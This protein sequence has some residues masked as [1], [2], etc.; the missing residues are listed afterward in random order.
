MLSAEQLE[1]I[2]NEVSQKL[3]DEGRLI[4]AGWMFFRLMSMPDAPQLQTDWCRSAFMAGA[5]HLFSSITT[6]LAESDMNKMNLIDQELRTFLRE[7][8]LRS[9]ET[10]STA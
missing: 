9:T 8:Q 4:E 6:M 5:Q 2:A 7:M 3:A 1:E 10:D